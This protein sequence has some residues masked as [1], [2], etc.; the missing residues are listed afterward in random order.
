MLLPMRDQSWLL[1]KTLAAHIAHVRP[2]ADLRQEM[3]LTYA[4]VRA[5]NNLSQIVQPYGYRRESSCVSSRYN[6]D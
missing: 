2:D 5:L 4:L 1:S 6:C 3:L